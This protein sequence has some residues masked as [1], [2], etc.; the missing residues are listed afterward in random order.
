MMKLA[1]VGG[2][3]SAACV[4]EAVARYIAPETEVSVAV[5]E[6]GPNL[7]RG[8]VF[9]PDGDEI[10]AN[11]PMTE[12]SARACDP[13][14]GTRWLHERDLGELATET[15]VPPRR[16]VGRYLE[17]TAEQAITAIR[18]AGSQVHVHTLAVR[19]LTIREGRLQA[20]GEEWQ[21]GP[22]DHAVLCLGGPPSYDHYGLSGAPGFVGDPYP[23]YQSMAQVHERARVGIVGSGLTAVDIVMAL[24]ARGH[25]GPITLMSRNGNLPA[26][27]R[28]PVRHDLRHLTV[29]RLEELARTNGHLGLEDVL[30]LAAAELS[31]AGADAGRIAAD[32]MS[33]RAPAQRLRDDLDS[34]IEDG[35]PG[36]TVLRDAMVA[37]GQ[38]AWYLLSEQDK[39]RI[40]ASHQTLM[41]HCCPMPPGN[42]K[43][44]LG[45][46]ATGQLEVL[47]GIR[48]IQPRPEG[49]FHVSAQRDI[50]VDIVVAASTPAHHL[51]APQAAPLV[52][53]LVSQGL[54]VPHPY[55]GLRVD[56]TSSRLITWRGVPSE[57][58]HALGDI[59]HGAYLF[60]FGMPGLATRAERIVNDI[61]KGIFRDNLLVGHGQGTADVR[62]S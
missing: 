29:A 32:I 18:A 27:R 31:D 45:M 28:R 14:H 59:T 24:R 11:L 57:R 43:F 54:A 41:R 10:L 62:A 39:A 13:E 1:V 44:L 61:K 26:V 6:P 3:P 25:Q 19:S 49:G 53:S 7:W 20:Q 50:D 15:T 4:V 5:F 33:T 23:L 47:A 40:R 56:R 51:P 48:S 38:D 55:G 37:S 42:A 34:A 60:T 36:W 35:D 52:T 17:D 9:Q 16:V 12:M 2:G 21:A 22:F 46:F 58:L 8:R 30:G